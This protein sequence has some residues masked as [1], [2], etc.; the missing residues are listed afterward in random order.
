MLLIEKK[1]GLFLIDFDGLRTYWR[2]IKKTLIFCIL[3]KNADVM[4]L[5]RKLS[6]I[7]STDMVT[8]KGEYS[9]LLIATANLLDESLLK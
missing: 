9:S 2:V 3:I 8:T 6:P 1:T 5:K 7:F 4:G